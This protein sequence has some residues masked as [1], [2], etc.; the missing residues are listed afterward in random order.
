MYLF[1]AMSQDD[2]KG[3]TKVKS[4]TAV[5][6]QEAEIVLLSFIPSIDFVPS[7]LSNTLWRWLF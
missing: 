7:Q 4:R 6:T 3:K 1:R 5:G 2:K